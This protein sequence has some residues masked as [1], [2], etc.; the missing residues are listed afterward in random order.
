MTDSFPIN[1]INDL[2]RISNQARWQYFEKL[3]AFIFEQNGF[4][5]RQNVVIKNGGKRQFDVIAKR[6]G[7]T[8]LVE[9]KKWKSRREK[10]S[11]L[12]NA[13]KKHLE[14]CQLYEE[15]NGRGIPLIVTLFEEETTEYDGVVII[16]ILK[17]NTVII[18]TL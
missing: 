3:V 6:Y 14:R 18:E 12:K 16:P 9:C 17:L 1:S 11:A 5:T 2:V 8:Y 13:V 4:E 10:T 15:L 7:T